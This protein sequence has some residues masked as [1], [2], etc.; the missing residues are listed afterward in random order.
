MTTPKYNKFNSGKTKDYFPLKRWRFNTDK[1]PVIVSN[2]KCAISTAKT[3]FSMQKVQ[4]LI[5][6]TNTL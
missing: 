3:L 1:H 5:G 4:M 6:L 2:D